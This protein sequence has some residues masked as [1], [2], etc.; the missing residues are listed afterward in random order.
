MCASSFESCLKKQFRDAFLEVAFSIQAKLGVQSHKYVTRTHI[1]SA[2]SCAYLNAFTP[3]E[4]HGCRRLTRKSTKRVSSFADKW[5]TSVMSFRQSLMIARIARHARYRT[6]RLPALQVATR[7]YSTANSLGATQKSSR[8]Q[9]TVVNDD[10]RV[11]WKDLSVR[12]K[13]ART[14]QQSFNLGI[15]SLGFIGTVRLICLISTIFI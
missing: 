2:G 15:I 5:R 10:G 6:L 12:E 4:P 7:K 9:V 11:D 14:T 8:Q 1:Y 3:Y 13:A